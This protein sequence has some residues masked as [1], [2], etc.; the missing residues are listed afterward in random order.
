MKEATIYAKPH[1]VLREWKAIYT[2]DYLSVRGIDAN[3]ELRHSGNIVFLDCDRPCALD[4]YG[5]VWHI[6][7]SHAY[8][9]GG[10]MDYTAE[11]IDL[12]ETERSC[13]YIEALTPEDEI[14]WKVLTSIRHD[15]PY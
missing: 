15:N 10:Y 1:F 8:L 11:I 14:R 7:L 12:Y 5:K 4:E 6:P 13:R 3:N 2:S 9:Q